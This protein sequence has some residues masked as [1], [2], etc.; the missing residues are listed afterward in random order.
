MLSFMFTSMIILQLPFF[1]F[2][3]FRYKEDDLFTGTHCDL[4]WQDKRCK[5]CWQVFTHIINS[6]RF[7][8]IQTHI[9]THRLEQFVVPIKLL[10]CESLKN[11]VIFVCFVRKEELFLSNIFVYSLK[12]VLYC[13][14]ITVI[15]NVHEWD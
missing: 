14:K 12:T 8:H 15:I 6:Y 4:K 13:H 11:I 1:P 5:L 9:C 7:Y 2:L 3:P 10:I